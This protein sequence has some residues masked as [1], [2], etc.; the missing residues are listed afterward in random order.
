MKILVFSDSHSRSRKISEVL[1]K[2]GGKCDAVVF[3]GDG[4][5]DIEYIKQKY[6]EIAFFIVKG[7]CDV[8]ESTY[9]QELFVNFDGIKVMIAH[10]HKHGVKFSLKSIAL[11]AYENGAQAVFF[12]HTHIPCDIIE[13]INDKRIQLFNPGSIGAAGTY[14]VVNTSGSIL[15]TNIAEI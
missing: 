9:P 11:A 7:N 1:E 4:V 5:K 10:G 12:G 6:P 8:F 15:V 3:C 2:H 14:G 13:D